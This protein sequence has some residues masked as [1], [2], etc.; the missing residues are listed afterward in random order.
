MVWVLEF[1]EMANKLWQLKK[2]PILRIETIQDANKDSSYKEIKEAGEKG[3]KSVT[4]EIEMQM[5]KK[6][7]AKN[8]RNRN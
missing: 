3:S 4:Y 6:F 1:G 5:A 2:K 7:L 8:Q